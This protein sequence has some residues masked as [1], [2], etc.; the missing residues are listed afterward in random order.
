M[1]ENVKSRSRGGSRRS[2]TAPATDAPATDAPAVIEPTLDAAEVVDATVD[3]PAD[4]ESAAD[5]SG[6]Q[7]EALSV[8][9]AVTVDE[10][11]TVAEAAP[12]SGPEGVVGWAD[13][14]P[15]L[16]L[17]WGAAPTAVE[18]RFGPVVWRMLQ[19]R[20]GRTALQM[21]ADAELDGHTELD[22][23]VLT[24]VLGRYERA[25][26]ARAVTDGR[27]SWWSVVDPADIIAEARESARAG[28]SAAAARAG[29]A[30]VTART[31]R[32]PGGAGVGRSVAPAG[33][34]RGMVEDHLSE[35]P[36]DDFSPS[37][38]A[39]ALG[40]SSGAV[41]NALERLVDTGAAVQSSQAP[42][43]YQH[44]PDTDATPAPATSTGTVGA[45]QAHG[46]DEDASAD[47][48]A[49]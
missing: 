34:L 12:V 39:K 4:L 21:A 14:V 1:S 33:G 8:P 15:W 43:R 17:R 22:P 32:T 18:A 48:A 31:P 41:A 49:G 11:V 19:D 16:A 47:T 9:E 3:A 23:T 13:A 45:D 28:T 35:H 25:G 40:R 24:R 38:V 20:P 7:D 27:L 37:Q 5:G 36:F 42:R 46:A 44:R 2:G 26:V 29:S 10:A 30:T 6:G